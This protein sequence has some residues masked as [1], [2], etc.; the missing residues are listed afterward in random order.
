MSNLFPRILFLLSLFH[1][2]IVVTDIEKSIGDT[3]FSK[4]T[5]TFTT[6]LNNK[7]CQLAIWLTDS[8]GTFVDTIYVTRKIAQKGMGNRG[9]ELDSRIGGSRL[10]ALPVWAHQR[11]ENYGECNFYPTKEKPLPDAIT[12]ATPKTGEFIWKW[13]PKNNLE[14]GKYTYYIEVNKSFDDNEYH[15]YSWYRGQPSVVWKG[16]IMVGRDSSRSAA[17]II[18]HGHV[19]GTNGDINPDLTTLTSSLNLI[20]DVGVVF[21]P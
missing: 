5:F 1:L 13:N 11:G 2:F 6:H 16:E 3:E 21:I 12:S 10:S 17:K 7:N 14:E 20:E 18:G 4:Q 15:D 19:A 9:G 8:R